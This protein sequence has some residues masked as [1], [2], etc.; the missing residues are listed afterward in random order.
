MHK[1]DA[2]FI[3]FALSLLSLTVN[4]GVPPMIHYQGHLTDDVG[5]PVDAAV[6]MIFTIYDAPE[7]PSTALWAETLSVEVANGLFDV[8]LGSVHALTDGIFNE[9]ARYLGIAVGPDEE[10]SPR[11][12]FL[13][14]P[15][16]FRVGTID[17]ATGGTVFGNVGLDVSNP[18]G[19]LDVA[20]QS[21][22]RR[23]E[24]L[25]DRIILGVG[26]P[27]VC[28]ELRSGTT[29]GTPYIDFAN[30]DA[31][32]YDAR[33]RLRENG[34]LAVEG[35]SGVSFQIEGRL[36]AHRSQLLGGE[37]SEELDGIR[38]YY[39][40][41]GVAA[42]PFT[43]QGS[44]LRAR[45]I[46]GGDG[47]HPVGTGHGISS[48]CVMLE[49]GDSQNEM[50]PLYLGCVAYEPCRLW[51]V[52]MSVHGPV[53]A[54][55][56][57]IQGLVNFVNNYNAAEVP[58]KGIGLA[59]VTRPGAGG[60]ATPQQQ[61]SQTFPLDVGLAIVGYSGTPGGGL[62]TPGFETAL[63]IGGSASGWMQEPE[64]SQI[65]TGIVIKEIENSGIEFQDFVNPDAPALDL[66]VE[67]IME[68]NEGG[69]PKWRL[70]QEG[71]A[72]NA[73]LI[74]RDLTEMDEW[75]WGGMAGGDKRLSFQ[76]DRV[77][78]MRDGKVGIG[79]PTPD[80]ILT[81][82]QD[83]PT[84]PIADAWTTYSSERWKED[85]TPISGALA[86][87]QQ[88]RGVCFRWKDSKRRDIG[89]I[90]EEVGEVLPE[91]VTYEEDGIQAKSLD[92]SRLTALLVEAVKEQ[93]KTI[94]QLRAQVE[95]L[96]SHRGRAGSR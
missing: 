51:G 75:W 47:T 37:P 84:D 95:L 46:M 78:I 40:Y 70:A 10:I 7:E 16:A 14:A 87:V 59:V 19:K 79:T 83:S 50:T 72:A 58:N 90:A 92:Y 5:E 33:I 67:N 61:V 62:K 42:S 32:D 36:M 89:M 3:L 17:G 24:G 74:L 41:K 77:V 94:E 48:E 15:Y 1:K 30:D 18:D 85:I 76:K 73:A 54:Q 31:S 71:M 2:V 66:N 38:S 56:D 23:A 65:G 20:G 9:P 26:D 96:M 4:A 82:V 12:R 91:I 81:V 35:E 27:N 93:Q 60:S 6:S 13:T 88:L 53:D 34:L 55:A 69:T 39:Y 11:T 22:F 80:N 29:G 28:L 25:Q 21:V 45:I 63:Q 44:A 64:T 68:V 43:Y 86:K 52:D 8:P 57:L 49:S